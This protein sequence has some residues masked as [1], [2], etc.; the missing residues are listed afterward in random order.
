MPKY[1]LQA[2]YTLDGVKGVLAKGGTARK[3]AVQAAAKSAGGTIESFYFAFGST[4][5][6]VI[7]DLPND[8]AAAALVMQVSAGGGAKVKTTTL[9]SPE[10]IDQAAAADVSYLSPGT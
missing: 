3:S 2:S 8:V 1:L 7:A 9:L 6:F 10:E 4:D 5:V